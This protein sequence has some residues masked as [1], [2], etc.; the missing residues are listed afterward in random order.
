[1]VIDFIQALNIP[2]IKKSK[3]LDDISVKQ[4]EV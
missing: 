1:M 4:I 3:I 2:N